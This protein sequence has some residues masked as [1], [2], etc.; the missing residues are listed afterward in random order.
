MSIHISMAFIEEQPR[1]ILA[2]IVLRE[3]VEVRAILF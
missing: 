2:M 3:V 1:G